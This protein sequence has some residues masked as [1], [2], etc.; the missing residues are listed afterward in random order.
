MTSRAEA[1]PNIVLEAMS[2][3]CLSISTDQQPMP[4]FF[5]DSAAYYR[6]KDGERL[7]TV[8]AFALGSSD[9]TK[10]AKNTI[11]VS[12]AKQFDWKTTANQTVEQL[13]LATLEKPLL[14]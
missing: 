12:R 7:A 3:G 13:E 11:A 1:C 5:G 8:L 10:S 14:R 6:A 4:E 2:Y 9:E